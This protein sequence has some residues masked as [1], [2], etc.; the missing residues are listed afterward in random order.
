MRELLGFH[1]VFDRNEAGQLAVFINQRQFLYTIFCQQ[2]HRFFARDTGAP[3]NQRHR[4]HAFL[5]CPG[6]PL[7]GGHETQVAIGN[8][9][10][11]FVV[12]SHDGQARYP[13]LG[14]QFVELFNGGVRADG[15][16]ISHH[17]RLGAFHLTHLLGLALDGKVTVQNPYAALT[18]HSNRHTRFSHG[19]HSGGNQGDMQ[20]DF[21]GKASGRVH[22][23][24]NHI[25]NL[26]Q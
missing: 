3:G 14:T 17:A 16:G 2:L 5:H 26:W 21:F 1:K 18:R 8:D 15:D 6:A 10:Q 25:C 23:G 7:G 13:I 22:F 24:G 19:V 20:L 9:T 12:V 11:Q 4:R